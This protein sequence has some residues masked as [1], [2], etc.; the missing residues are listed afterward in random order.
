[1][2]QPTTQL[3]QPTYDQ[4]ENLIKACCLNDEE[5]RAP[6]ENGI[7]LMH[8]NFPNEYVLYSLNFLMTSTD[9]PVYFFQ[10]FVFFYTTFTNNCIQGFTTC[11]CKSEKFSWCCYKQ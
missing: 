7:L 5:K 9:K 11:M 1:M 6:A 8:K 2:Q 3:V 4:F 10:K